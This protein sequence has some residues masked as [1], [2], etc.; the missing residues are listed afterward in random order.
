MCNDK[1]FYLIYNLHMKFS[2]GKY[3]YNIINTI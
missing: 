3:K 2:P 1:Y